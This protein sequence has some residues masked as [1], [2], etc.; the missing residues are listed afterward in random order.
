MVVT[1]ENM[2]VVGVTGA[3]GYIGRR[4]VDCLHGNGIEAVGIVRATTAWW[5]SGLPRS[6]VRFADLR[7]QTQVERAFAGLNAVVHCGAVTSE[8][9]TGLMQ[10]M[11]TNVLGTENVILACQAK[12]IRK[13]VYISS[14][15]AKP[16]NR[17]PYGRSKYLAEQKLLEH[18][19]PALILRPGFVYGPEAT[20]LFRKLCALVQRFP[21]LPVFDGGAQPVQ[22]VHVDDLAE[23]IVSALKLLPFHDSPLTYETASPEPI[24]FRDLLHAIS[25]R[26]VGRPARTVSI[27]SR[28]VLAALNAVPFV[29]RKL[30]ITID[31]VE[32]LTQANIR[33]TTASIQDLGARYRPV[34]LGLDETLGRR[35]HLTRSSMGPEV[36][37]SKVH[38]AVYRR[39]RIGLVGAGKMGMLHAAMLSRMPDVDIA[40]ICDPNRRAAGR[41]RSMGL[42]SQWIPD[43]SDGHLNSCDGIVVASPTFAH[44]IHL[45]AAFARR[46]PVFCEKPLATTYEEARRLVAL[47]VHNHIPLWIDYMIPYMAHIQ[48]LVHLKLLATTPMG[49]I[50][51]GTLRCELGAF[52]SS[53]HSRGWVVEKERSGGGVL[54]NSG[55]HAVSLLV[56][57][58]GLPRHVSAKMRSVHSS[59]VEDAVWAEIGYD[60]FAI[61]CW[62]SWSVEGKHAQE[63][64]LTLD[65]EHGR[66]SVSDLGFR[67]DTPESLGLPTGRW[68]HASEL[69]CE[70]SPFSVT[71]EYCGRG[72]S[73]N[74]SEF[75][76][77]IYFPGSAGERGAKN[78]QLAL[79]V[80]YLISCL[81]Q[82]E[83]RKVAL[84]S[85]MTGPSETPP[86]GRA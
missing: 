35:D 29:A 1:N 11:A 76:S 54:I 72:Y 77:E 68:V 81:Y 65:C 42:N 67:I 31:N 45:R 16:E 14:Q 8:H 39:L 73:G 37:D 15:S 66:M 7:S 34:T 55:G 79:D 30:P 38:S 2:G 84:S 53:G 23:L 46:I 5:L 40:W 78:R 48:A 71:P 69:S 3:A 17:T 27:P 52:T 33:D 28:L 58:L 63:N 44:P 75:I 80:E 43:V 83:G 62:F 85:H 32:G 59:N 60:D 86:E 36:P 70:P 64:E 9:A 13:V 74:L 10:S 41:L 19:F 50:L 47:A 4:V 56:A 18:G 57:L 82:T 26:T 22:M 49:R 24:S 12:G 25:T 51:K 6:H 21:V 20:G 61:E